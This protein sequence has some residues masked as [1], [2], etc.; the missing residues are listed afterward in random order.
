MPDA[1]GFYCTSRTGGAAGSL[2][3]ITSGAT[4]YN[5]ADVAS[6][7]VSDVEYYYIYDA[8]KVAAA[9]ADPSIIVP[10]DNVTGTGAWVLQAPNAKLVQVVTA[11]TAAEGSGAT[12]TPY[13]ATVPAITEGNEV[14]T[15]AITP[16]SATNRLA[17]F[18]SGMFACSTAAQVGVVALH[19]VGVTDALAAAA[20]K[21]NTDWVQ[22]VSLAHNMVAGGIVEITFTIRAGVTANTVYWNQDVNLAPFV[23]AG[24]NGC[25]IT[26]MEYRP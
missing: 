20:D 5:D 17:I 25:R 14:I 22:P 10:D 19:K 6:V 24:D 21:L 11:A 2:D 15:V 12:I 8:T 26:V 9:D 3:G 1:N 4:G 18:F 16:G 13:D 7:L 23:A